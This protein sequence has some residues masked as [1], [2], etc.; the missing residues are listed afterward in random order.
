M[1]DSQYGKVSEGASGFIKPF[2]SNKY[3]QGST[4][5]LQSNSL[6]AKF[7][8]L[9]LALILFVVALRLGSGLLAWLFAPSHSPILINGMIN[10]NQMMQ[11]PQDPRVPGAIPILRSVN[12]TDGLEFTWSVWIFVDNF[13]Y[14]E[15]EYKHIFHKGN[16][17]INMT[18]Q[19]TG[20]NY[21]NNGPGLYITPHTNNL[22]VIMST[23]EDAKEEVLVKDLPLNKWVNVIIRVSK[24]NQ[25]DIYINGVLAKR[26]LLKSVPKQNYGDVFASM[27]GG[28]SGYTSALRYFN[29]ALGTS[30]IQSLVDQ[31]PNEKMLNGIDK[32]QTK[33]Q[34]LS[35]RWYFSRTED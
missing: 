9:I 20:V 14:K 35:S 17:G 11:I 7:A 16:D 12:S 31:G 26:H 19:P 13:A 21:P 34:Y 4:D 28:F 24:Q 27:N 29:S 18:N 23:F 10:A 2:S 8:F 5:F 25:L 3:L 30:Q 33:P 32:N 1:A 15:T 6:V 22:S